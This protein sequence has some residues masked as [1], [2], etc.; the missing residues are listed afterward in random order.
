MDVKLVVLD[1]AQIPLQ[2]EFDWYG[3]HQ[4]IF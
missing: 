3:G 1:S 4:Y 2:S